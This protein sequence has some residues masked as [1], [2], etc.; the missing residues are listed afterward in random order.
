MIA[1]LLAWHFRATS[2]LRSSDQVVH[3]NDAHQ[4]IVR[5]N[6]GEAADTP[7]LQCRER[8]SDLVVLATGGDGS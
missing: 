2:A 3:G 6:H 7:I 5:V 1:K 4:P 8:G